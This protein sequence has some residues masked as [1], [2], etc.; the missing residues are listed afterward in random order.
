MGMC[1]LARPL[2]SQYTSQHPSTLP[3]SQYTLMIPSHSHHP[4]TPI[5]PALPSSQYTHSIPAHSQHPSTPTASQYT[6]I[7]P[8]HPSTPH[9]IPVH[10][11]ASQ[12]TPASQYTHSIPVHPQYPHS[13]PALT[14][15]QYTLT[16]SPLT[17]LF[18]N[19]DNRRC[20]LLRPL[21]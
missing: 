2:S 19:N 11:T 18:F 3:S 16:S 6:H 10:L 14:S 1:N 7:I 12:Y 17:I 8:V 5:I 20:L 15:S 21:M 4:S 13:I 9:S